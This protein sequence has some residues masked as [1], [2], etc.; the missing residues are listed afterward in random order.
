MLSNASVDLI[1]HD[2]YYVVAHFHYVLSIRATS[3]II[4]GAFHYWPLFSRS[5]A[6]TFLAFTGTFLFSVGVNGVFL[7]M[8]SLGVERIPRRYI[9]YSPL[10]RSVNQFIGYSLL[11]TLFSTMLL[12]ISLKFFALNIVST[13]HASEFENFFGHPVQ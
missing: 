7:P 4:M 12:F 10:I 9:N 3:A 1:L 6:N 13:P 11:C 5:T 8:H 2:C